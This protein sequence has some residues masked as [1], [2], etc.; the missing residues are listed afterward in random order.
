MSS[1]TDDDD[2]ICAVACFRMLFRYPDLE[3]TKKR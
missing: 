2:R 1:L 3:V